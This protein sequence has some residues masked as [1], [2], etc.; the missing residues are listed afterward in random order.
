MSTL[1]DD[2]EMQEIFEG[3]LVETT[4][5]IDAISID[6][7]ELESSGEDLE[8]LNRIFRSFHTIKGTSAFMA[9]DNIVGITHHA[10]DLLNKLRKQELFVNQ[11]II[12]VLLEVHDWIETLVNNLQQ[13]INEKVDY[14]STIDQIELIRKQDPSSE[15][16]PEADSTVP[17]SVVNEDIIISLPDPFEEPVYGEDSAYN[18]ILTDTELTTKPGYFSDDELDLIQSAFAELN[19][20]FNASTNLDFPDAKPEVTEPQQVQDITTDDDVFPLAL[21]PEQE[22]E[23]LSPP[24]PEAVKAEVPIPTPVATQKVA[25]TPAKPQQSTAAGQT[26]TSNETIR[27]DVERV[28]SLLDLSGELVLGR[29]RLAQLTEA[30]D[31]ELG[32]NTRVREL[33]ET[34]AQIDFIT[35]EIQSAVMKMRMV[36]ISK[37]YQKSPRIVRDLSKEFGKKINIVLSGE[38]TEIDRGIIE[39]LN[40]PLV[41]MIRNSCDHGIESPEERIKIGKTPEGTIHLDADQEGNNIVLRISDD[42]KGMDPEKLKL[43]AVEKGIISEEQA[44]QMTRRD[45]FQLVFLPGF[46]T[47]VKVSNV[48]GRGVGMDVVRTNIQKIKGII[49]I[50]SELGKGT[51]FT[52]KLPLTL[53]IIQGLLIKIG[54]EIYAIPLSSVIEVVSINTQNVYKVNQREVIRIREDVMPLVRLDKVLKHKIIDT[55]AQS[56]YVVIVAIGTKRVGFVVDELLGQ[57]EIVIK[58]LGE[59]LGNIPGIAG[60]TIL[61]DGSV[62][63]IIDVGELID[64]ETTRRQTD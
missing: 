49:E 22:N 54:V 2:P 11:S 21:V 14:Q 46:S 61:G 24:P 63:M 25:A 6:L 57:Q 28:E 31:Y 12:D 64:L 19:K 4:E 23:I 8:L 42:G 55:K 37:L 5:L 56:P 17:T 53:A 43:K 30:L 3:Y 50:D 44:S 7:M 40:D 16:S 20:N 58:S 13:G 29:N 35:S 26:K 39:E 62:I 45:A 51:T 52:I 47:A 48:S 33:I 10:E 34:T 38:E 32:T 60:S 27:V 18:K 9:F 1:F 15:I 41:H 36:P 59:Y